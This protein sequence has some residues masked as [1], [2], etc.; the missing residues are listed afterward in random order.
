MDQDGI[1][2]LPVTI[3][4]VRDETSADATPHVVAVGTDN[5]MIVKFI[6]CGSRRSMPGL[7]RGQLKQLKDAII[8]RLALMSC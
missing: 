5:M 6:N 7:L 2:S 3:P 1:Y 8:L 4:L